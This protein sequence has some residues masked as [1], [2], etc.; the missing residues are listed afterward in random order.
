MNA[1]ATIDA[2]ALLDA[3]RTATLAVGEDGTVLAARGGFGGF[4]GIDLAATVGTN[5]FLRLTPHDA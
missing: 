1:D 5:V 4:L 2:D 3:A